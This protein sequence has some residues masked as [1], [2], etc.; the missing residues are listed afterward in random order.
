MFYKWSGSRQ[1][2]GLFAFGRQDLL[3]PSFEGG[4]PLDFPSRGYVPWHR[5]GY[6][7]GYWPSAGFLPHGRPDHLSPSL[8]VDTPL[9]YPSRGYVYRRPFLEGYGTHSMGYAFICILGLY[10]SQ[11]HIFSLALLFGG[12]C[13]QTTPH[14]DSSQ[15]DMGYGTPLVGYAFICISGLYASRGYISRRFIP[16]VSRG[17]AFG[18]PLMGIRL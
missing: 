6:S 17:H 2:G 13:L 11:G 10:A 5:V 12:I 16:F 15:G 8:E 18:R 7:V 9:D 3:S 14:G 1:Q 4:T